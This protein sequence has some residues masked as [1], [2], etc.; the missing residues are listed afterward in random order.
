MI[1]AYI[2]EGMD[3]ERREEF[4]RVLLATSPEGSEKS[5]AERERQAVQGLMGIPGVTGGR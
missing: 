3:W 1:Y 5:K 2:V 4:D